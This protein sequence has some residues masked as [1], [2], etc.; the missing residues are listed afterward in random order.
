VHGD[1]RH[2]L[3]EAGLDA[4]TNY[5]CYKGLY[6]SH[7]DRNFHEI[8]YSLNRQFGPDG[9]YRGKLLYNFADNHDV[10]RVASSLDNAR[11]LY[12]LYAI[13][14]TM[15]GI[16]SLYYGS[17]WGMKGRRTEYSDEEL[18][19]AL[20]RPLEAHRA[21]QPDLPRAIKKLAELREAH[22]PLR[23]GDYRQLHVAAEQLVFERSYGASSVV[24]GIN[25]AAHEV[26]LEVTDRSGK[27]MSLR[28]PA[29]WL[30]VL[31]TD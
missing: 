11:D 8:A 13:L 28:I 17:E 9:M 25:A 24:V 31:S 5:E 6:S 14:F 19:P 2:W 26:E 22:L 30:T 7:V 15:P 16:P 18:R 27:T 21:P 1:Y 4:V 3:N 10:D 20:E 23:L 12:S 29:N